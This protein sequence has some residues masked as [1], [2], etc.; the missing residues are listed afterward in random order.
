M[1]QGIQLTC[2]VGKLFLHKLDRL[3][4]MEVL[5]SLLVNVIFAHCELLVNFGETSGECELCINKDK[6]MNT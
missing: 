6:I 3:S 5:S 4:L 2:P 1:Y